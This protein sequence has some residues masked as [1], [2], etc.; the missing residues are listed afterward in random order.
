MK[1]FQIVFP[2]SQKSANSDACLSEK[3]GYERFV[4][5]KECDVWKLFLLDFGNI[6]G[7]E[8]LMMVIRTTFWEGATG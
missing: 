3:A 5:C 8:L 2:I 1:K 6:H 7:V 4:N